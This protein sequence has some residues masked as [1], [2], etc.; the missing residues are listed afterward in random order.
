[1]K[2]NW[3]AEFKTNDVELYA[4]CGVLL[5]TALF[6][7]ML[8][9]DNICGVHVAHHSGY[10]WRQIVGMAVFGLYAFWGWY[11]CNRWGE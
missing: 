8:F 7:V 11:I 3:V 10:G 2:F 5:S 6:L 4:S 1:M 9:W